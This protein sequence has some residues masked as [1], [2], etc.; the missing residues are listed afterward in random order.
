MRDLLVVLPLH[1]CCPNLSRRLGYDSLRRLFKLKLTEIKVSPP[2]VPVPSQELSGH[3]CLLTTTLEGT[4]SL[5][6]SGSALV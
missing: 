4:S 6:A 1:L 5:T 3:T 2:M